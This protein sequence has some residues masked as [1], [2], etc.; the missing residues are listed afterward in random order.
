MKFSG[1]KINLLLSIFFTVF[2]S[3]VLSA[4]SIASSA[5]PSTGAS[6]SNDEYSIHFS[7][8]ESLNTLLNEGSLRL[9]QGVIQYLLSDLPSS[10]A[11]IQL[12]GITVYPNPAPE[13]L[14]IDNKKAL[15]NL[16]Y[17]LYSVDGKLMQ[18]PQTLSKRNTTINIQA[19]PKGNYIL[20]I[21]KDD[22]Y[23]Q[24][25]SLIKN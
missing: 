10:T 24:N 8:G 11:S 2:F 3:G 1:I 21:S 14:L 5:F 25:L 4:Q 16:R 22:K 23:F 20:K 15:Q 18:S 9:S 19:L 7:L 17:A 13:Y 6:L 12:E